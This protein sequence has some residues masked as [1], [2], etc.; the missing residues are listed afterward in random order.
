MAARSGPTALDPLLPFLTGPRYGRRAAES[1]RR[2][3]RK[4]APRAVG[5]TQNRACDLLPFNVRSERALAE[6]VAGAT[7]P[8][9]TVTSDDVRVQW[10]RLDDRRGRTRSCDPTVTTT[11]VPYRSA[12]T[13]A[14]REINRPANRKSIG[15]DPTVRRMIGGDR[16]VAPAGE[17]F[18][19]ARLPLRN[20]V[21]LVFPPLA[22][23]GGSNHFRQNGLLI[24]VQWSADEIPIS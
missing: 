9:P 1:G 4:N 16:F 23:A 20:P 11:R 22:S 24:S 7:R 12:A 13:P 17:P 8:G 5:H 14:D 18:A 6:Q 19:C 2:A 3:M 15:L 10:L 21:G